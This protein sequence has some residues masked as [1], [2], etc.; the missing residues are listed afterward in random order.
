MTIL[1]IR[2]LKGQD[3][4]QK[5]D[6][7]YRSLNGEGNFNWRYVFPFK[8]LPAEEVMVIKKKEH[9]FSLDKHEE[10]HPVTFVCQI[11]DNDIFTPDDFLGQ[12]LAVQ[13][14]VL[15]WTFLKSDNL[16]SYPLPFL[17]L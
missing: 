13:L 7:H 16:Q 5:T 4:K 10:K 3:K 1:N 2:W 17:Q 12:F 15:S 14:A 8:Y 11:W 6:V 9:F